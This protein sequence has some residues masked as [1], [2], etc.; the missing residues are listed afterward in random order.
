MLALQGMSWL[1]RKALRLA[2][3]TLHVKQ[4]TFAGEAT[5]IDIEQYVTGGIKAGPENRTLDWLEH[6]NKDPIFGEVTGKNRFVKASELGLEEGEEDV[7]YLS[8]GWSDKEN[9]LNVQSYSWNEKAGWTA[10]QASWPSSPTPVSNQVDGNV[11][12][13]IPDHRWKAIL[14]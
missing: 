10:N 6:D 8:S 5:H 14:L 13:G 1:L 11:D 7:A 2:N 3:V 12:M 4:Y 9:G